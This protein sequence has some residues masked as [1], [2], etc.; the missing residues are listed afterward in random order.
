LERC[1]SACSVGPALTDQPPVADPTRRSSSGR[2]EDAARR[3]AA[4]RWRIAIAVAVVALLAI[5]GFLLFGGDVSLIDNG[6]T[7]PGEFAFDLKGVRA[8]AT[9]KTPPAE[10]RDAVREAGTGVKATMDELFFRAFVDTDSWG[11]YASAYELFDGP[12]AERA[13]EDAEVLTL[14]TDASDVFEALTPATSTL[15]VAILTNLKDVPSTA[16]AEVQFLADAEK[17]D[18]TSTQISST[19]SF[20]L[21][22]VD[23]VWRIFAYRVDRGD[24]E[25]VAPSP[26]GS[27]S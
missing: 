2:V 6:P 3:R 26:S 4:T 8:S 7:G 16:V 19:G 20:F 17:K 21:R 25:A 10:L 18:G 22:Q 11:D 27:P 23:G 12:A 5:G 1:R 14:G 9:S 24:E 13:E 15:S